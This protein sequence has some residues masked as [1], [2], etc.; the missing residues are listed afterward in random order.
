M[1]LVH[2]DMRENFVLLALIP[3]L[4]ISFVV[5][6]ACST[7]QSVTTQPPIA[8]SSPILEVRQLS[9]L[10]SMY[11]EYMNEQKSLLKLDIRD[12]KNQFVHANAVT[13]TLIAEDGHRQKAVF[14]ED[15]KIEKYVCE[16]PLQHHEDYAI[17]TEIALPKFPEK[18][19]PRFAFHCCDPVPELLEHASKQRK[20]DA[21]K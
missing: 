9:Y 12:E 8:T 7:P 11:P 6:T 5:L 20:G 19:T 14:I 15:S 18:F 13:A 16:I 17:E 1:S 2:R 10:F 21:P 3:T 4:C